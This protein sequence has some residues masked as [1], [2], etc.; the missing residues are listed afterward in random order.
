[1]EFQIPQFI[2]REPTIAVGLTFRQFLTLAAAGGVIFILFFLL[3][4]LFWFVVIAVLIGALT[5]VFAFAQ[6][7]GQNFPVV[8][9][10][11]IFYFTKPRVYVWHKRDAPQ[12]I[13][14]EEKPQVVISESEK[15]PKIGV[16]RGGQLRRL[17]KRI[18]TK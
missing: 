1:M 7:G 14:K 17:W 13:V 18:E 12:A 2:A 6:I 9:K 16:T 3:R 8:L 15:E 4:N 10:N 11:F 5:L